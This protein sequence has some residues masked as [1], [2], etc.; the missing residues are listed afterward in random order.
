ML[1]IALYLPQL[2]LQLA[3]RASEITLPCVIAVGSA[4]R[5]LVF[6]ANP[7]ARECGIKLHMPVAAAR[8]LTSELVVLQRDDAAEAQAIH[9]LGC[10]A[11]QFTPGIVLQTGEGLLLDVGSTLQLHG[12]IKN[13]LARIHQGLKDIGYHAEPGVAP[14][15]LAAWLLAKARHAGLRT[16]MC[17][18]LSLV[19]ERLSALPLWLLGW[20]DDVLNTL[21]ILGVRCIG[22]CLKLPRDGFIRRFGAERLLHLDRMIGTAP[23][24]RPC[25]TPPDNFASRTEFGFDVVDALM[26][27]FPLKRFLQELEGFLRGRGAGVQEW[28]LLLDH[29]NHGRS[30]ITMRVVTPE[31][32]A[33]RFLAL[34][35]ERLTQ[36]TLL[37]PVLALGIAANQLLT[38]TES[39]R[40]FIPDP[41]TH[42]IG[43]GH[44][45]DKLSTRLGSDKVYRLRALDDHRPEHAWKQS[46]AVT[47]KTPHASPLRTPRPLWLLKT[48]RTLLITDDNPLCQGRLRMLTG[49]ER[50]ESGW[51]DGKLARRDYY[52]ARNNNGET[53]WIYRE[54]QRNHAWY[55]H[56]IFS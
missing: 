16:R 17:K 30:R 35:R 46:I 41:R 9:N 6:C 38:F 34:A 55:L 43:W 5:P 4:M 42:A 56:G 49:P 8:A 51:W 44:L 21:Q 13:L 14:T 36:I 19:P 18:E 25:F 29:A 48:P 22:Q 32:S 2:P 52:V 20:S 10:W 39:N 53:F 28:H 23:D 40:S 33:E 1:W 24:P 37:G 47:T 7:A 50:I 54:H 12:G 31:R 27:L 3:Q 15:P 26:L 11:Y 45:V